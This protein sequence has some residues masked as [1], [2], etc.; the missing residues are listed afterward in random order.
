MGAFHVY[1]KT[2]AGRCYWTER[3]SNITGVFTYDDDY[4]SGNGNW[5]IDPALALVSGAQAA[6][7]GLPG[8]FRD[9][10][11]DRWGRNLIRR[12]FLRESRASGNRIRNINEIDY[13]LG[14]SDFARQ[15]D[16][17]F[18]L[19][20]GGAF[21]YPSSDVPK[22]VSLP[23]L[24][25]AVRIYESEQNEQAISYLLDAGS[26]SLG[27]A[28]PKAAVYDGEDLYMAKFPHKQDK[29]DVVAWEWIVLQVA[30]EAGI[31]VPAN[32]LVKIDG[33]N[34]LLVRRFDR[35]GNERIGYI[36]AMTLLGLTDFDQADY[37]EIAE[38]IRDICVSV[39]S[40]LQELY[41]RIVLSVLINNTDDH[42]RNHGFLR[43]GCGWRLSPV[44]DINPN[45]DASA[46]RSTSVFSEVE[47]EAALEAL[48]VYADAF[49]LTPQDSATILSEVT[50]A[51]KSC[52]KYADRAGIPKSEQKMFLPAFGL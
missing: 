10:A 32:K 3:R 19:E 35:S 34:V 42:L 44:F 28:R 20:R 25:N 15:G 40:D 31:S 36:S 49:D 46:L 30:A 50:T 4:L 39:K 33:Q 29:W 11:P 17:R 26:A 12:R 51:V 22:L 27:G 48:R 47:K 6:K 21:Q 2:Y 37:S 8:A 14:V 52:T 45:P 38:K 13:L 43:S 5:A 16:L 23:N 1:N 9:T 24:L 18:S 7:N 41:R